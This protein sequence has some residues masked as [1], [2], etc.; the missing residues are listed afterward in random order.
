MALFLYLTTCYVYN[1]IFSCDTHTRYQHSVIIF[2]I[3]HVLGKYIEQ[4]QTK[5]V[6]CSF[7]SYFRFGNN[8]SRLTLNLLNFLNEIAHLPFFGTFHYHF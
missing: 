5:Q 6:C 7:G 4:K 2:S 8:S 3:V 1:G